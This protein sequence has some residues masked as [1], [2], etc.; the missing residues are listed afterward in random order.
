MSTR[1]TYLH[2]FYAISWWTK[3]SV[4]KM[5]IKIY[6]TH[7]ACVHFHSR[8]LKK[9]IMPVTFHQKWSV[10]K[11]VEK[12]GT[13]FVCLYRTFFSLLS[14]QKGKH[15]NSEEIMESWEKLNSLFCWHTERGKRNAIFIVQLYDLSQGAQNDF[16]WRGD[17]SRHNFSR[18]NF[19]VI[20]FIVT[21]TKH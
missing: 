9:A 10:T 7:P 1:C 19:V 11:I 3:E 2:I 21:E 17:R 6:K 8:F 20:F 12:P 4:T 5:T 14:W 13:I 16:D 18:H 15:K